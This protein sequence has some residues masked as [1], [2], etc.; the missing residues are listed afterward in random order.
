MRRDAAFVG[1]EEFDP[2]WAGGASAV[3]VV[4]Y[5]YWKTGDV[6]NSVIKDEGVAPPEDADRYNWYRSL[7]CYYTTSGQLGQVL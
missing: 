1:H 4:R 3:R 6:A 2:P 7:A 5:V